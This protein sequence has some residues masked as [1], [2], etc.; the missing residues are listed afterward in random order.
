[1]RKVIY[2]VIRYSVLIEN[3]KSWMITD[4]NLDK[5][6]ENLFDKDRLESRLKLFKNIR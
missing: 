1:M 6:R 2:V 3:S 5:Y 4:P